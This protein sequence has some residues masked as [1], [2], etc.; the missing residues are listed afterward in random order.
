L[1][2]GTWCLGR[3]AAI[4]RN[5][6]LGLGV[7]AVK[8]RHIMA[9]LLQMSRH[10][11]AHHAKSQKRQFRHLLFLVLLLRYCEVSTML[12]ALVNQRAFVAELSMAVLFRWLTRLAALLIV[13]SVA[14]RT[15]MCFLGLALPMRK[16]GCGS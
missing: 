3:L 6:G 7:R 5:P 1:R 2:R 10:W 15:A 13:L 14:V 8:D 9:R 4:G 11:C 12:R 16:T